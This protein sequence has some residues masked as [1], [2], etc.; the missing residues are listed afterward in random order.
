MNSRNRRP[1]VRLVVTEHTERVVR[2]LTSL[3]QPESGIV[4]LCP[5][6]KKA[7]FSLQILKLLGV[8]PPDRASTRLD[9]ELR[10]R[11]W[12]EAAEVTT[13][14]VANANWLAPDD[15]AEIVRV[16]PVPVRLILVVPPKDEQQVSKRLEE[17]GQTLRAFSAFPR[18]S[19]R[20]KRLGAKNQFKVDSTSGR[21]AS[22]NG[23]LALAEA[24]IEKVERVIELGLRGLREP[25]LNRWIT[26]ASSDHSGL[27]CPFRLWG[28]VLKMWAS[29]FLINPSRTQ[30]ADSFKAQVRQTDAWTPRDPNSA[31]TRDKVLSETGFTYLEFL[32]ID[33]DQVLAKG[34][35]AQVCGITYKGQLARELQALKLEASGKKGTPWLVESI[36]RLPSSGRQQRPRV[37]NWLVLN[38]RYNASMDASSLCPSGALVRDIFYWSERHAGGRSSEEERERIDLELERRID[39]L[40]EF[41]TVH[42]ARS[43]VSNQS[44]GYLAVR[45]NRAPR[46][47]YPVSRNDASLSRDDAFGVIA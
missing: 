44:F 4:V 10:A 37:P 7:R 35:I 23:F 18:V 29:G 8:S 42:P 22:Q 17:S 43:D 28:I 45:S 38:S 24:G 12:L 31:R 19:S 40:E 46:S 6:P 30:E 20:P 34:D 32:A 3:H 13:V 1:P 25:E 11:S 15:F 5:D 9:R 33:L 47:W 41:L 14:V 21:I 36:E 39:V 2:K 26:I 27:P 16:L